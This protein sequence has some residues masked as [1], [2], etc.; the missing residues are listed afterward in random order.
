MKKFNNFVWFEYGLFHM[1]TFKSL[2]SQIKAY[3]HYFTGKSIE[4]LNKEFN[5]D[6]TLIMEYLKGWIIYELLLREFK[7]NNNHN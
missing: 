3:A 2:W 4:N 6:E 5:N 1:N 7:P